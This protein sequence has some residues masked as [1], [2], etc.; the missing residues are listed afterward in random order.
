[1]NGA[2]NPTNYGNV[3]PRVGIAYSF[4]HGKGVV[5]TG[6]GLFTGP[7]DYSDVMVGWQGASPFTNMDQP[8]IPEFANPASDLV[9]FGPSG[10]VGVDGPFLASQAYQNFTHNGVYPDPSTLLQFP[11]GYVKRKFPNAYAEETSLEVENEIF[12]G[13][14]VSVGYQFV[15]ALRLPVYNSINGIPNGTLPDGVQSFTPADPNFGFT[16]E[17]TASGYSIYHGGTLSLRKLLSRHYSI[18]ANYTFSKSIDIGTDVQLTD[19][20]MD[21]LAPQ[22][23]RGLGDNDVRRRF[24]L[25]ALGETPHE[26]NPLLRNFKFSM[27]NTLQSPHYYTILAGF[28][29]NGDGFPFSDRVGNITRNT[30]RGDSSYTTDVRLQRVFAVSER[31]KPEASAEIFN[32]F[33][34]QNVN[35]IDTVYGAATFLGRIPEKYGDG[36]TSAANPTFGTPNYVAPARQVQLALRFNF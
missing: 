14:Y 27:L 33:N 1:V 6:F 30:Y 31:I 21:Y 3:Q 22:L 24:V 17:A 8:L 20:P 16:L 10:I 23:D 32:L 11:L 18:L 26:W 9:G 7:F 29:V 15:H 13:M 25:T 12:G 28:D 36:V 19:T 4:H 2:T 34:R 5:R 35:G